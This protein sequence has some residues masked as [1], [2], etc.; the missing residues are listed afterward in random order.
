MQSRTPNWDCPFASCKRE[1]SLDGI[2]ID[3]LA[4]F[5]CT[6]NKHSNSYRYF[7]EALSELRQRAST[8]NKI[9]LLPDGTWKAVE[10]NEVTTA[11]VG[12]VNDIGDDDVQEIGD[13]AAGPHVSCNCL[14]C[15]IPICTLKRVAV[16]LQRIEHR[17]PDAM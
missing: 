13:D 16:R 12:P 1:I 15:S 14:L 17:K 5:V 6:S 2:V 11:T 10:S 9:E 8:V 4:A 3:E 7:N